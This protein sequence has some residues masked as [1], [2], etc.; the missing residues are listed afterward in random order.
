MRC[1]PYVLV[2]LS[3]V[4]WVLQGGLEAQQMDLPW[5]GTFKVRDWTPYE[6]TP[7]VKHWLPAS[8]EDSGGNLI[9]NPSFESVTSGKPTSWYVGGTS[10]SNCEV[11]VDYNSAYDQDKYARFNFMDQGETVILKQYILLP[12]PE[13]LAGKRVVLSAALWFSTGCFCSKWTGG[14]VRTGV[15]WRK[16]PDQGFDE[17][18]TDW[19]QAQG[20]FNDEVP[21]KDW[22]RVA[23]MYTVPEG[24]EVAEIQ[25]RVDGYPV[26]D[27]D[28]FIAYC[29]LPYRVA[30]DAV[31]FYVEPE[32]VAFALNQY[33][34]WE[35]N[36]LII[37]WNVDAIPDGWRIEGTLSNNSDDRR[38]LDLIFDAPACP[39]QDPTWHGGFTSSE[40]VDSGLHYAAEQIDFYSNWPVHSY[41][42]FSALEVDQQLYSISMP[43]DTPRVCH[44]SYDGGA[45]SHRIEF[46]LGLLGVS[47]E[48]YQDYSFKID[49]VQ[50]PPEWGFRQA[51]ESYL[52]RNAISFELDDPAPY[53]G[54][55][56]P[57][58]ENWGPFLL[59]MGARY[60]MTKFKPGQVY[61]E[62]ITEFHPLLNSCPWMQ[63]FPFF[64]EEVGKP[65]I[66]IDKL[67]YKDPD[68]P[69]PHDIMTTYDELWIDKV[70]NFHP[71]LELPVAQGVHNTIMETVRGDRLLHHG[72]SGHGLYQLSV[73]MNP[74]IDA[75]NGQYSNRN[76]A[77]GLEDFA[78]ER[79]AYYSTDPEFT[80][81]GMETDLYM[82]NNRHLD[83]KDEHIRCTNPYGLV[84]GLGALAPAAWGGLSDVAFVAQLQDHLEYLESQGLGG[85]YLAG[86]LQI[87]GFGHYAM[88]MPHLDVAGFECSPWLD[89]DYNGAP[90]EQY[91]RRFVMHHRS[92]CRI[93]CPFNEV[94]HEDWIVDGDEYQIFDDLSALATFYGFYPT[95]VKLFAFWPFNTYITNEPGG[96]NEFEHLADIIAGYVPKLDLV[97]EAGWEP[98]TMAVVSNPNV[99]IERYGP[100]EEHGD[101]LF[102]VLNNRTH[103]ILNEEAS[104]H[105]LPKVKEEGVYFIVLSLNEL[106]L[107]G[108]L[109]VEEKMTGAT[110]YPDS[111]IHVVD[112]LAER[113]K[114][115][116]FIKGTGQDH[117]YPDYILGPRDLLVFKVKTSLFVNNNRIQPSAPW[118]TTPYF[119]LAGKSWRDWTESGYMGDAVYV[120][121][122]D[123]TATAAFKWTVSEPGTYLMKA[124][125]P[126]LGQLGDMAVARYAAYLDDDPNPVCECVYDQNQYHGPSRPI[127]NVSINEGLHIVRLVVSYA[128]LGGNLVADEAF[129]MME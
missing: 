119:E 11:V 123:G 73:N 87:H 59:D 39:D 94:E 129:L 9:L 17:I 96:V 79:Y 74:N 68:L 63:R 117:H 66:Q 85:S 12:D 116:L 42:P 109:V 2:V 49:A 99:W 108:N 113:D 71:I 86:N 38:A 24:A 25:L 107:T 29:D 112:L 126:D 8:V 78:D 92:M 128:Q 70:E 82:N 1:N 3:L 100:A 118:H 13:N 54:T 93:Y 40:T 28:N 88:A 75:S 106:G 23:A 80:F 5:E 55:G 91:F 105:D 121:S 44:T 76:A 19:T 124:Q 51:A 90:E 127:G 64:Q 21:S 95:L 111:S 7:S 77:E 43:L 67:V 62:D 14:D 83:F 53:G 89:N 101:V 57:T 15:I 18:Q 122:P 26:F 6:N 48:G 32:E 36:D 61:V 52:E 16:H 60:Y 97:N 27:C 81:E 47:E 46:H 31:A 115:Q 104:N 33:S 84:Y 30:F 103:A 65:D 114:D 37:S 20:T 69:D 41:Y 98:V 4:F 22:V 110:F 35:A 125:W 58:D 45:K 10:P 34:Q 56:K 120:G 50:L 72:I 102:T